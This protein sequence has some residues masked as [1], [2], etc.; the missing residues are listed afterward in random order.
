[1]D[2][3]SD[4]IRL[5]PELTKI[6]HTIHANPELMFQEYE[7]AKL[8]DNQLQ[9]YGYQTTTGIGGTG[10]M[11]ILDSGKEGKT[12]CLR[13][14][15]DALPIEEPNGL[16][17][18]SKNH[19]V[20]HACGHDGHTTTMLGVANILRN[21]KDKFKGKIKFIFQPAE[22]GGTGAVAMIKDGILENPQIDA[23]FWL[24]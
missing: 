17:Y 13:A 16:Q 15:M 4:F 23:I 19:G 6:R 20:M 21:Y 14:E 22:E 8:V 10:V 9:S 12:V 3:K 24:A 18:K 11:A 7:T 2:I 1:M 5:M